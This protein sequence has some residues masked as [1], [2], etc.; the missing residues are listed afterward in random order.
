MKTRAPAAGRAWICIAALWLG[1]CASGPKAPDWQM[2]A[3]DSMQ[4]SVAAYL[5]GDTR[6]E[7]LEFAKARS[8]LART[9]RP[10]LMAR[11]ELLRCAARVASLVFEPCMG[12]ERLRQDAP[13]AERAYA[14]YLAARVQPQDVALLPPQQRAAAAANSDVAAVNGIADPLSRLV[15]AAVRIERGQA[16]PALVVLAVDTASAQGWRRPLLAWLLVQT[17]HAE[18]G[19]DRP[20][21]ERLRRRIELVQSELR[22]GA[23]RAAP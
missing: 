15:A 2:N 13:A 22:A 3:H 14:Y 12:F 18:Q 17:Q 20:E 5:V 4:R 8:E 7:A 1:A 6:V 11:A 21:A 19:G 23:P 16:S 10:D 9:G